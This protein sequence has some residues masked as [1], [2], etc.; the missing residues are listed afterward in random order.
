MSFQ[1]PSCSRPQLN[2]TAVLELPADSRSDEIALQIV[3]CAHCGFEGIAVY[4]ESRRGALD[5]DSFDHAGYEVAADDLARLRDDI[6]HCPDPRNPRC[7]CPAHRFWGRKNEWGRWNGLESLS[8]GRSFL[9]KH[10]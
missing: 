5:S 10:R 7:A 9:M 2:I 3:E 1:C 4:E 6:A 8:L